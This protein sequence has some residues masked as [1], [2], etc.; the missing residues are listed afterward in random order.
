[1]K[2]QWTAWSLMA[3]ALLLLLAQ[4]RLELAAISAPLA[5]AANSLLACQ[6]RSGTA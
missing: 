3:A 2:T 6:N 4:G 1:M 5:L